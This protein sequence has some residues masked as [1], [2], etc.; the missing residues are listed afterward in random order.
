[1][2]RYIVECTHC[3]TKIEDVNKSIIVDDH[4]PAPY[5]SEKCVDSFY[6]SEI[7][8]F[9]T[10]EKELRR[11]LQYFDKIIIDDQIKE[12]YL[13]ETLKDPQEIWQ[14]TNPLG[15]KY[16]YLLS[17]FPYEDQT[18]FHFIIICKVFNSKPS[19]I[20]HFT[21]GQD[22]RFI[23]FYRTSKKI[24]GDEPKDGFEKEQMVIPQA[25][26]NEIQVLRSEYFAQMLERRQSED[27]RYEYF[28][29]YEK[30]LQET[31]DNPDEIYEQVENDKI[32]STSVK[33]AY[34]N[35]SPFFYYVIGMKIKEVDN[36][37]ILPIFSFPT[38]DIELCKYFNK[39]QLIQKQ[40]KS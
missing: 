25:I 28:P 6:Q 7:A 12:S 14:D 37:V 39:G 5:C 23:N 4:R 19:F 33:T 11:D 2:N 24:K 17:Q 1:M 35:E 30:F 38:T 32:I 20:L 3:K 22:N 27:I 10:Q 21:M 16:Y 40:V 36:E 26:L 34:L 8:H 9:L 18:T 29:L 31:L 15:E 13:K